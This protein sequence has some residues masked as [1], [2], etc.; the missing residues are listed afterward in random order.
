MTYIDIF[1][2]LTST[3]VAIVGSERDHEHAQLLECMIRKKCTPSIL[4]LSCTSA[5]PG[6]RDV[7]ASFYG[8][9]NHQRENREHD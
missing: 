3:S 8:L 6:L 7:I 4:S 9:Q 1:H 2:I 5:P